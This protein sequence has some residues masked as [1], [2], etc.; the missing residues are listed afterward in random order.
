MN[1]EEG[2]EVVPKTG[3]RRGARV[4]RERASRVAIGGGGGLGGGPGR[5]RALGAGEKLWLYQVESQISKHGVETALYYT[6]GRLDTAVASL[7]T[8]SAP[9]LTAY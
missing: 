5:T 9:V 2:S 1:V 8:D 3:G 6:L 4:G 7:A